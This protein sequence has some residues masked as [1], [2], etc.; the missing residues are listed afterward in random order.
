MMRSAFAGV[1]LLAAAPIS[2]SAQAPARGRG[3]S[4]AAAP[5]PV[6]NA[7]V[8][9]APVLTPLL[10]RN[11][12]ARSIGPAIMGGRVSEIALDPG[13]PFTFYAGLGTGGVMKTTDNGVT[14][15]AVFEKE[16][17][18]SVGAVAVS[19]ANPKIVWVGTGEANDRNSSSWGNGVHRSNDGGGSW[20]HVGLRDS[21]TIARIVAHPTD[22]N[23]AYV[24]VMG[25]LW[26]SGGERGLYR[27]TDGGGTWSLVLA[28]D[29]PY[30]NR[31]GAGDVVIDPANPNTLYAALYARQRKPWAFAWGPD[32]ADGR[33]LGGIFRSA[34]GG[35]TWTKLGG[36][37]PAQTGRIGLA[38]YPKNPRTVYAV[39]QSGAEGTDNIDSPYSKAGG[40]FR[41]DDGG[42]TWTRQSRLNPR[43][44][45]FSQIRVDP[46]NDKLV[47][48]LGFALHVSEDGG[49]SWREDRFKN[50][51]PDVHALVIDPKDPR[52]I[53]MGTDGGVYQSFNRAAGWAH[54]NNHAA[55]EFYRIAVDTSRPYR[56]C[57]GLQDNLNW[58]GPSAVP[59][60]DGIRNADWIN[61]QGGDGFWCFFDP[62]DPNLVYT[63]SQQGYAHSFDLRTGEVRG[64]RPEPAE[65]QSAYRFNWNSPFIPSRHTRGVMYLGGNHVFRLWDKGRK[66]RRIS[67]D[68]T[69]RDLGRMITTGSGAETF[70]VVYALAES[71]RTAGRLWAGTDDGK[72]WVTRNDG[73]S[74]TDLTANLPAAVKGEW[75]TRIEPGNHDTAV[76]YLAVDAHRSGKLAPYVYRTADGGRTWQ[77]IA[78]DLPADGPVKVVRE[79]PVNPNLLFAGTE[80]GLL[81]SADCGAHW[82]PLGGL[83]TVAVDDLVI[84]PREM[85][86]VVATHGRSLYIL[87]DIRPLQEL[88]AAAAEAPVHF[89]APREAVGFY[90]RP[91]WAEWEGNGQFRGQNPPAGAT[92][93]VYVREY[94]GDGIAIAVADS[95]GKPVANLSAPGTPGFTRITWNLMPTSDLL[96]SYGGEGQK[97]LKSGEYTATLTYGK[98]TAARKLKV[99]ILEGIETR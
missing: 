31:V 80:F 27:T 87:D 89:F 61:I 19:P 57:G 47:Y 56:I 48:V 34:D 15:S 3:G 91:G 81:V 35:A 66:W 60:K 68:L 7:P 44:F 70:G 12:K 71:P 83:P 8:P 69:T 28:A 84:H 65:G 2:L 13:D 63:E 23:T 6:P 85:D 16:A 55:G 50:V 39:V 11:L 24:A 51:H 78:G 25:D 30:R 88:T 43:P 52:R 5:A 46:A 4:P 96:N 86:L 74:W 17:V 37:L 21:R 1:L 93:T 79:D 49:R 94:T 99:A 95:A 62:E 45:Y 42:E 20:K 40:V 73:E 64:L 75:L 22:S 59:S 41:S 18:A 29:A 36:G 98:V 26:V 10:L 53:L 38:V 54:L 97:F 58:V 82:L 9:N 92:F 33:D 14:M 90:E 32:A 67:D 77:S 76:A 72:L